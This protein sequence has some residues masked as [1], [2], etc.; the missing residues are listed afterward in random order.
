L[1][2]KYYSYG[3]IKINEIGRACNTYGERR[4]AYRVLVEKPKGRRPLEISRP[5]REDN[6]KADVKEVGYGTN[7]I[8]LAQNRDRWWAL[9]NAVMN[10]RFA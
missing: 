4:G 8:V 6:I 9:V 5:R 1:I 10:L 3:T 7:W 2:T